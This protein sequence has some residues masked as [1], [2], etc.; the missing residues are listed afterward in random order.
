MLN[1]NR[2][3][4]KHVLII[5]DGAPDVYREQGR[6]P[7]RLADVRNADFIA[8]SGVSG[9]MQTQY[10][11]LSKGSIVAQLG[12]LGWDPRRYYPHGR[13]SCELLAH[14][15]VNL[16]SD[17]LVFRANLVTMEGRKLV[18]YNA[19]YVLSEQAA[20]LVTRINAVTRER[21]P[22]FE[23]YHNLDFRNTLVIRGAGVDPRLFLCAEPHDSEGLEFDLDRL[24]KLKN[25]DAGGLGAQINEY[26]A[27]ANQSLAGEAANM[28]FPWSA[29]APL[30]L[31]LFADHTGFQGK[32]G[33]VGCLDFLHGIARSG[34]MDFFKV[35][36][37]S[38]HT[39]YASKGAK[40]IE[41]LAEGYPL[42]VCHVNGP[43]EASH[44]GDLALKI[45][46]IEAIDRHILEPL[47]QYFRDHPEELGGL[48]I[49][50]DHYT[51][52][53]FAGSHLS[54]GEA[55]SLHPVP[56]ALWNGREQD[57]VTHYGEDA[58][59]E[60]LY[61]ATP[62]SHL[63]L[64]GILGVMAPAVPE[65]WASPVEPRGATEET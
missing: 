7:L 21:F 5:P 24:V 57:A 14:G 52:F 4:Q 49:A 45:S 44:M 62:V 23:L 51:N 1:M 18:S 26:L 63:D 34:G 47:V 32:V 61:G 22:S 50:P 55:H 64:L 38:P 65:F 8:R 42:V 13:A 9:L 48:M 15:E 25:G 28:L 31:P 12:M 43:D 17:D 6:S 36:N 33:I 19:H 60:G 40:V 27:C 56:F 20:P 16:K 29:S 46:S 35:G 10:A 30:N 37:G 58:A 39:D 59:R 11:E 2:A 3:E 53:A 41:L 54:R